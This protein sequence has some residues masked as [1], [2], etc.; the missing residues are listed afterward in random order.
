VFVVTHEAPRDNPPGSV[1]R[2]VTDG[3]ERA[4]EQARDAAGD[5]DVSIGS[6]DVGRQCLAAGLVDELSIHLVPVL[7]GSGTRMFEELH[8]GH[9]P[10]EVLD[11]VSTP[12]ATHLHYRIVQ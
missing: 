5:R 10:L 7:F 9:L 2:F 3:V 11:V 8:K 6:A 4:L 12:S 1:Y